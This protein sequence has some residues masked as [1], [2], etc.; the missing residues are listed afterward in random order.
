MGTRV[1]LAVYRTGSISITINKPPQ[2]LLR[3]SDVFPLN[4]FNQ[5]LC[6]VWWKISVV[7]VNVYTYPKAFSI[8]FRMELRSVNIVLH[9][10]HLYRAIVR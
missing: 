8:T 9:S 2:D 3:F 6:R 10:E 4:S 5:L 7:L 1:R